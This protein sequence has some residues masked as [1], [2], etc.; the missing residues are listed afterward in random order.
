M[1]T[2]GGKPIRTTPSAISHSP[3]APLR[4]LIEPH[5]QDAGV[6]LKQLSEALRGIGGTA[7]L[8]VQ[9]LD[10]DALTDWDVQGGA[11][12]LT[13]ARAPKAADLR[14]IMRRETLVAILHGRL[15]PFDALFAGRMRVGGDTELGKRIV[16]HLSDPAHPYVPPC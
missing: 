4:P 7:R 6:A 10:G 8:H 5:E 12:S 1:P 9:V 15:A 3:F 16:Q 14:L 13:R 2:D 11:R